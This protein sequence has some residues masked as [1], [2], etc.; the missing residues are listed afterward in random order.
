MQLKSK[1]VAA[2][3]AIFFCLFAVEGYL[4]Y[5]Q[6]SAEVLTGAHQLQTGQA[7]NSTATAPLGPHSLTLIKQQ[8]TAILIERAV[9]YVVG[10]L[11]IFAA[12]SWLLNKSLLSPVTRFCRKAVINVYL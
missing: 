1:V 11:L 8:M 7:D 2:M 4:D 9:V 3:A 6:I 10:L 5:R 12:L